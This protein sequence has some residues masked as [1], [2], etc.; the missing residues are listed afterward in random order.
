MGGVW[1]GVCVLPRPPA[2]ITVQ[3]WESSA[4]QCGP[5]HLLAAGT[6]GTGESF[7]F[8]SLKALWEGQD[9]ENTC[10]RL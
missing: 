2:P 3:L 7:G 6:S 4:Q 8:F 10:P 1:G 9:A 5:A